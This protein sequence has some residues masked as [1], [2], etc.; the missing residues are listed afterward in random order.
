MPPASG[1]GRTVPGNTQSLPLGAPADS[2]RSGDKL[3]SAWA[4]DPQE[5]GL[6]ARDVQPFSLV[7]VVWDD[8]A[9]ELARPR[10]GPHPS[11]R[12]RTAGRPGRTRDPQHDHGPTPAPRSVPVGREVRGA[13][14]PLWV[15]DSDGVRV[16]VMPVTATPKA[17]GS[18]QR[19]PAGQ[20]E[21]P[22]GA[23]PRTRRPRRRRRPRGTAGRSA[24]ETRQ[25][26]EPRRA[27]RPG[28]KSPR[29]ADCPATPA[30]RH[31]ARTR[32][33]RTIPAPPTAT[34]LPRTRPPGRTARSDAAH[35]TAARGSSPGGAG[36]RTRSC[37]S[38][39]S[40]TPSTVKAA[41]VHH[42]A[43][44]Q[45]Q[46][47]RGARGH[48]RYLPLP[49]QEQ[50]L[51]RHRLQLPRRQVR[52]HLRGPRGRRG[53]GRHGRTHPRLQHR[54]HGHRR[55]RHLLDGRRPPRPS[56]SAIAKLTRLEARAVT[57]ATPAARSR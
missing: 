23:A 42:T 37:A 9:A 2:T 57:A 18:S 33:L 48:P 38:R 16:R 36:A 4:D 14:A 39:N 46:L 49:R 55:A 21:L 44:Q 40:S 3:L 43:G 35:R 34:T 11:R 28:R 30:G 51:A 6:A 24:G 41:F 50:R 29:A 47:R 7:G 25:A 8:A 22:S 1:S 53:Q 17:T 10:P 15:G 19:R 13:T 26:R 56:P 32:R 27:M 12:T 54:Q 20:A 52:K 31:T 5:Q 45:L